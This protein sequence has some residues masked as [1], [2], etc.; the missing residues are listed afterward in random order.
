MLLH[1]FTFF[2]QVLPPSVAASVISHNTNH[3]PL[4]HLLRIDHLTHLDPYIADHDS[5]TYFIQ[6][7]HQYVNRKTC[8]IQLRNAPAAESIKS[9]FKECIVFIETDLQ[10]LDSE[11]EVGHTNMVVPDSFQ[12]S[13]SARN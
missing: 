11:S 13:S 2:A 1:R 5:I 12:D 4:I 7:A 9:K 3:K 6:K 10:I 8:Y